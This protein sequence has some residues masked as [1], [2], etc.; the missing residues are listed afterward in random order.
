MA[1]A[2]LPLFRMAMPRPLAL[3]RK[4]TVPVGIP[5]PG[6]RAVTVAFKVRG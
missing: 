4:V 6:A 5:A 3:S 1:K 2:A